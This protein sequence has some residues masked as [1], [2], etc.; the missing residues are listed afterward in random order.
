[1]LATASSLKR[2]LTHRLTRRPH[3]LPPARPTARADY[4]WHSEFDVAYGTPLAPA[5]RTGPHTWTRNFTRA[6]VAVDVSGGAPGA[7]QVDLLA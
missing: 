2:T 3:S 4:C 6:N 5:T 7:G 1:M